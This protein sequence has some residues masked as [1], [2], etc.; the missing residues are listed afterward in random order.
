MLLTKDNSPIALSGA[1]LANHP[2]FIQYM[3]AIRSLA[4][5][6]DE[7]YLLFYQSPLEKFL[8]IYQVL[9]KDQIQL[10]LRSIIKALKVRRNYN[11]PIGVK[12]EEVREKKDFWTYLIFTASLL[13]K[14]PSITQHAVAYKNS[15]HSTHYE[16][17]NPY[18]GAIKPGHRYTIKSSLSN[19]TNLTSSTLLPI[20]FNQRC[21][22]WLYSDL[23]AFNDMLELVIAPVPGTVLG[24][25]I[26]SSNN[27]SNQN[28]HIG[29][30]LYLL[31]I[32]AKEGNIDNSDKVYNY[33]CLTHDGYAIAVPD[34][35]NYYSA[36]RKEDSNIIK[37]CFYA[38][39][40]HTQSNHK[41]TF[42]NIGK[43]EAM[44]LTDLTVST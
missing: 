32:E 12:P 18:A 1:T 31:L 43:K 11:L 3:K 2:D 5:L 15:I 28:T 20:I 41:V 14:L 29:H 25:L 9:T 38:L 39:N 10:K 27:Q 22:A 36:L 13:H 35:F 26:I 17:W 44:I 37:E 4:A 40:V 34:I 33:I 19:N 30:E 6:P 23:K 24:D 7:H 16:H 8:A 21:I 42:P